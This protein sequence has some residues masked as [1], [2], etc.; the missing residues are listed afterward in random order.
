MKTSIINKV[1]LTILLI[2]SFLLNPTDLF[3]QTTIT[4]N[5][6]STN[7]KNGVKTITVKNDRN[8]F[9]VEYEGDITLSDDD[10]DIIAISRGGF[11]EIRKSRF[12]KRRRITIES[13][14]GKLVKK[15]YVGSREKP[16]NPEGKNWLADILQ[17]LVKST[18]IAAQSR[19]DRFYKKGGAR[20]V[21]YEVE[22]MESDYVKAAYIKILLKKRLSN[23]ELLTVVKTSGEEIKSDYY[24]SEI[25]KSNKKAFLA[26]NQTKTAFINAV[27]TIDSDH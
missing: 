26:T 20:E 10:K 5:S 24:L 6:I 7:F 18:T 22:S 9:K 25:L 21:M 4:N 27:K 17:D 11:I 3:S 12:G 23:N 19:V 16:F 8:D 2:I 14:G 15:Y 1:T 13:E